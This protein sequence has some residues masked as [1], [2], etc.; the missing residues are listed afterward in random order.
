MFASC[1]SLRF[2]T[3]F[4]LFLC[5]WHSSSFSAGSWGWEIMSS[6]GG[7]IDLSSLQSFG[8]LPLAFRILF[9]VLFV[10]CPWWCWL[11]VI[12]IH[13][14]LLSSWKLFIGFSQTHVQRAGNA[15]TS[16]GRRVEREGNAWGTLLSWDA[17]LCRTELVSVFDVHRVRIDQRTPCSRAECLAVAQSSSMWILWI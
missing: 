11:H 13:C 17:L 6:A 15:L 14:E 1:S 4:C 2:V 3:T 9:L 7:V 10:V 8:G 12:C 16:Y 5:C